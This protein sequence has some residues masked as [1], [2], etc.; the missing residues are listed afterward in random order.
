[1]FAFEN[2][3]ETAHGVSDRNLLALAAGEDLRDGEWLAEKPLDFAGSKDHELIVGRKFV[4][5]E[6]SDDILQILVTLKHSLNAAS[7]VVMVLANDF[8]GKS[9]RGRRERID[10]WINAKFGN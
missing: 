9:A 1:M 6:N 8:L 3:L 4:H 7:D 10:G 5:A 2:L